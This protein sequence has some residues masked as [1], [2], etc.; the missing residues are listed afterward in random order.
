MTISRR[1]VLLLIFPVLGFIFF[2]VLTW[3]HLDKITAEDAEFQ[4]H[5]VPSLSTISHI[6]QN[7]NIINVSRQAALMSINQ[8]EL[9]KASTESTEASKES[10]R[11]LSQYEKGQLDPKRRIANEKFRSYIEELIRQSSEIFALSAAGKRAEAEALHKRSFDIVNGKISQSIDGWLEFNK[12]STEARTQLMI[13][14]TDRAHLELALTS[15]GLIFICGFIAYRLHQNVISP[16]RSVQQSVEAIA[17]GNY[18]Q[19]VNRL[20]A[21]DET[22]QL[23]RQV[24]VLR[25]V[26][27]AQERDRAVKA[28]INQITLACGNFSRSTPPVAARRLGC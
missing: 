7:I 13:S 16:I 4:N 10:L 23:A 8:D 15:F 20:S 21:L 26:A 5:V 12:V 17:A 14:E 22:G 2:A 28:R 9:A 19:P 25:R 11:M 27:E 1:I 6:V 18:S 24:D 3:Q